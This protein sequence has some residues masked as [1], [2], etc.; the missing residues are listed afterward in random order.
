[1]FGFDVYKNEAAR[2]K[3]IR[4]IQDKY[5]YLSDEERPELFVFTNENEIN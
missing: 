1:M 2:I 3:H 5:D 4:T